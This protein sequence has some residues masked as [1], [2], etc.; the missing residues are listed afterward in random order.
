MKKIICLLASF[1]AIHGVFA[2]SIAIQIIQNNP[3]QPEKVCAASYL[4]EQSII[5]F[6]FENGHIVTNSPV[7]ISSS[8]KK[9]ADELHRSLQENSDGGMDILCRVQV[10]FNEAEDLTNPEAL[11]LSNIKKVSWTNYSVASGKEISS[12]SGKPPK[13]DQNNNNESGISE[14][15]SLVASQLNAGLKKQ[16]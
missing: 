12:G 8:D 1:F 6:F 15:A 4:F 16:K 13:V 5:D 9:D 11:L 7:Y 14:F 2:G 10:D 3:A